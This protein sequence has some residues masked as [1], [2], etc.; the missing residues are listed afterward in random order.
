MDDAYQKDGYVMVMMI[1]EIW[2]T[3][4]IVVLYSSLPCL[5]TFSTSQCVYFKEVVFG[6]VIVP[7]PFSDIM[8]CYPFPLKHFDV[9]F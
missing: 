9:T 4:E 3:R 6:T 1:V 7:T 8:Y 2:Q 5:H